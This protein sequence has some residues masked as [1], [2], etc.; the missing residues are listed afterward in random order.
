LPAT[1]SSSAGAAPALRFLM[2]SLLSESASIDAVRL[3]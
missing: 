1:N 3:L 2:L